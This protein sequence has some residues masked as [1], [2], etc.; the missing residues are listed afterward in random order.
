MA[1]AQETG[2]TRLRVVIDDRGL[3]HSRLAEKLGL[4]RSHFTRILNA[5]RPCTA[6][7][8]EGIATLLGVPV[9]TF[10]DGEALLPAEQK[11][12]AA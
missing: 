8:A 5:E 9:E 11:E 2:K 3:I 12:D 6:A 10:F 7:N 4:T 1:V